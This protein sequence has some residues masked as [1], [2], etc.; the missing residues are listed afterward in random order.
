MFKL[1]KYKLEAMTQSEIKQQKKLLDNRL[2]EIESRFKEESQLVIN[3]LITL[4]KKCLHRG[5]NI[6][7]IEGRHKM[8]R[9]S[10]CGQDT[11][12]D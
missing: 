10:D 6:P 12:V 9:C 5:S 3:E 7:H 4:Q 11:H 1:N 8:L 2:K